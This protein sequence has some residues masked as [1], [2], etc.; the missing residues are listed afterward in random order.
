MR[1]TAQGLGAE[2]VGERVGYASLTLTVGAGEETITRMIDVGPQDPAGQALQLPLERGPGIPALEVQPQ[3]QPRGLLV[4]EGAHP[5]RAPLGGALP[6]HPAQGVPLLER[7]GPIGARGSRPE[8]GPA[9][10][11]F[12]ARS[13]GERAGVGQ[14]QHLFLQRE[15]PG[16]LQEAE[17]IGGAQVQPQRPAGAPALRVGLEHHQML[18]RPRGRPGVEGR[19]HP[20]LLQHQVD[21]QPPGPPGGPVPEPDLDPALDPGEQVALLDGL[22]RHALDGAPAHPSGHQEQPEHHRE[23]QIE[24]VVAGIHGE[25]AHEQHG[26]QVLDPEAGDG[27]LEPLVVP[28]IHGELSP[29]FEF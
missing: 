7:P 8:P 19:L 22:Q 5:G 11:P 21:L 1:L 12:P 29:E 9:Q 13:L 3:A 17:R 23:H 18:L 28:D 10:F 14:H 2:V 20:A 25:Q 6:V 26:G 4:L 15:A 27:Q 24:Q 16:L